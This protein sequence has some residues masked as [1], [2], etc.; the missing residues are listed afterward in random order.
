MEIEQTQIKVNAFIRFQGL[1]FIDV[2]K[3][4]RCQRTGE[5]STVADLDWEGRH[6]RRKAVIC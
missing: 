6:Q 2:Q 4:N 5:R 1:L 3:L